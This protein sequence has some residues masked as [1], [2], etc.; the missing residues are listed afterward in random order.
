MQRE[1]LGDDDILDFLLGARAR[2]EAAEA[3]PELEPAVQLVLDL[4]RREPFRM[5]RLMRDLRWF[6]RQAEKRGIQ[7]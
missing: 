7:L 2:R 3:P 1:P 5:R 4:K 6:T